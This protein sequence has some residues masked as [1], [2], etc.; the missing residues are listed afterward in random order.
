MNPVLFG[1]GLYV[2][3]QLGIGAYVARRI[4]TEADYLVAGR[5]L[6]YG[7]SIF[8]IFATWFGAE[9]C[10]GA[11]GSIYV[12]GLAGGTA[13]PFGYGLCILLMGAVFAVPLWRRKLTTLADFFRQRYTAGVER[14]AVVL[15]VPT[16]LLWAAAQVRAF[17]QVLAAASGLEITL[18]ITLAALVV[19]AYTVFGGLLADAWTDLVQGIALM[20]GL[21]VL[22]VM[23]WRDTGFEALAA[24]D[25]ARL[26]LF[27]GPETPWLAV[28]EGWAIPVCGS[29]LAAELVARV[30]AA[31]S[32]RVA[33]RSAFVAGGLYL[34]VGLIPVTM[35]LLGTTLL[36]GLEHPD[37]L[38]PLLAGRYLPVALYTLFAGALVSAILS[39]VDS[40]L[41][42]AS[43]LVSHN[44]IVPLRPAFS[45]R[46]KVLLARGGVV[47]FGLVAYVMALHAD[48]VYALV[49][50]ASAFGSAGLFVVIV[51]GLF[52]RIG[53]AWSALAALVTGVA[54]WIGGAYVVDAPYPYVTSLAAAL[55]AYLSTAA[56]EHRLRSVPAVSR[57][58]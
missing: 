38:L 29:V 30:I 54:V 34:A 35:G 8:T 20:T 27:G 53:G 16:S 40:A 24:V 37:Q 10:I 39:T 36:P 31:R 15:M 25:P 23:V 41:L 47:T 55:L 33:R 9:T 18:T 2:L 22:F 6:G 19:V 46:G 26:R 3:A 50:E 48:G 17:G 21:V 51:T 52:T 28:V 1:I 43:S 58:V 42:V 45:E 44:L 32:P 57:R 49:E 14:L 56:V 11:A 12:D 13:D 5:S 4:R 7:L